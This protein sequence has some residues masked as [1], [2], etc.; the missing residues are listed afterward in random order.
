MKNWMK[1]AFDP[2]LE[3]PEDANWDGE[4]ATDV[5]QAEDT[6]DAVERRGV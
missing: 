2:N 4:S 5:R 6:A 3:E 1:N